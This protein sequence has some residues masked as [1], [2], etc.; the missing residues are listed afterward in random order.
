MLFSVFGRSV[1]VHYCNGE[2]TDAV[3]FGSVECCCVPDQNQGIQ[4]SCHEEKE[5][6]CHP[7]NDGHDEHDSNLEE[8]CCETAVVEFFNTVEFDLSQQHSLQSVILCLSIFNPTYFLSYKSSKKEFAHYVQPLLWTDL[9]VQ[10]Q[11]F[12]I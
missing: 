3:L 9:S 11:T 2:I 8:S 6:H 7:A 12:L 1:E 10:F 5:Q 4:E